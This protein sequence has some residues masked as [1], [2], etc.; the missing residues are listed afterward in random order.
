MEQLLVEQQ[1][2]SFILLLLLSFVL[3]TFA[4]RRASEAA[5]QLAWAGQLTISLAGISML[6][7]PHFSY[8]ALAGGMLGC[9][10]FA[11]AILQVPATVVRALR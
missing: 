5:V 10:A 1:S 9:A 4:A 6:I 8:V 7:F 2:I 11:Y 3:P